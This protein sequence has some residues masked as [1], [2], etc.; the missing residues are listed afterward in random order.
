MPQI[1]LI[2]H[3]ESLWNRSN[4]FTGWT[5]VDLTDSGRRQAADVG[6]TMMQERLTP[7]LCFTS[8]QIRAIRTLWI[9]L[10]VMDLAWLP[11]V[12]DWRLNERHYGALQGFNKQEMAELVSPEAVQTWRRS[13]DVRPPQVDP[14]DPRFPGHDPRYGEVPHRELPR[15]ESLKDTVARIEPAWNRSILRAL[16]RGHTPLVVAHGN[17]L[18]GIVKLLDGIAN[19]VIPLVEIPVGIPLVY[20]LDADLKPLASRYIGPLPDGVKLPSEATQHTAPS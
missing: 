7:D 10:D 15:G 11:V 4:L 16:G 5:D 18:R 13:W 17:S 3:G 1:I 20:D 6:K 8:V 19:E 9:A 14:A 12:R 2:R